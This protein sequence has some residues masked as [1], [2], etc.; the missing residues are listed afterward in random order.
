MFKRLTWYTVN[1]QNQHTN[2]NKY[3]YSKLNEPKTSTNTKYD[4]IYP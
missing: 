2:V 3:G 4:P 1:P